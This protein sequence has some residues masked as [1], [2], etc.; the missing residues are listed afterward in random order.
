VRSPRRPISI[1]NNAANRFAGFGEVRRIPRQP[2]QAGV[3]ISD[4]CGQRLID[5]VRDRG[6]QLSERG[7]PRD[8]GPFRLR[9]EQRFFG[10]LAA[11]RLMARRNENSTFNG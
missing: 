11:E 4:Y 7:H 8:V 6:G 3:G 2:A 10:P 5:F 1:A 9:F